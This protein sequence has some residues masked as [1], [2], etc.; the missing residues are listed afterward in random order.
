MLYIWTLAWRNYRHLV[1]LRSTVAIAASTVNAVTAAA[2]AAA[3][4]H[5][6][7]YITNYTMSCLLIKS[8]SL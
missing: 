8:S 1:R 7:V 3:E 6:T 2:A 4:T 5:T